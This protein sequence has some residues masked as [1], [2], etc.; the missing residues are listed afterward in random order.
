MLDIE[1]LSAEPA[2][3]VS[4]GVGA[5]CAVPGGNSG[6]SWGRSSD[7]EVEPEMRGVVENA[8]EADA[9]HQAPLAEEPGSYFQAYRREKSVSDRGEKIVQIEQEALAREYETFLKS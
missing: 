9:R 6:A 2:R 8:D 1:K 4:D 5:C 7:Q 3:S